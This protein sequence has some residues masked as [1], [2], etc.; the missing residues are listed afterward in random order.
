MKGCGN[1]RAL[2]YDFADLRCSIDLDKT[3]YIAALG[4]GVSWEQS[5]FF[6]YFNAEL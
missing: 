3:K 2:L 4:L 6:S 5:C 1:N